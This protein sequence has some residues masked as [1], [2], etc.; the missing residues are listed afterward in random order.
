[1]SVPS[2]V[3]LD[4]MLESI[5]QLEILMLAIHLLVKSTLLGDNS[6]LRELR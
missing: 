4:H 5:G 6:G 2:I 1:M 3:L